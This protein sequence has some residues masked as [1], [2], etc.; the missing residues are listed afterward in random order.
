[1]DKVR[2]IFFQAANSVSVPATIG[3]VDDQLSLKLQAGTRFFA[4]E[5][6]TIS[7]RLASVPRRVHFPDG[8]LFSTHDNDA[9]DHILADAGHLATGSVV[10]KSG[11]IW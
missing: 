11:R 1:M 7:D 2:G 10:R 4:L 9:I 8:S 5:E 3:F 6:L